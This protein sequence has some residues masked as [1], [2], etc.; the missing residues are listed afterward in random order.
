MNRDWFERVKQVAFYIAASL[1]LYL[2]LVGLSPVKA[3]G[4]GTHSFSPDGHTVFLYGG[5]NDAGN[6]GADRFVV[7]SVTE[8]GTDFDV[9]LSLQHRYQYATSS[10]VGY[11]EHSAV[12]QQV[13]ELRSMSLGDRAARHPGWRNPLAASVYTI[14]LAHFS[15]RSGRAFIDVR[16]DA[17]R[18]GYLIV[19]TTIGGGR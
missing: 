12:T 17:R 8:Q 18:S 16:T 19:I 11:V 9:K 2:V 1:A 6:E 14:N 10:G 13:I 5:T 7:G 4:Q 3:Q 15:G